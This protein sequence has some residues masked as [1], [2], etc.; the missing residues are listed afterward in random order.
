MMN[1]RLFTASLL[2][3]A[4]WVSAGSTVRADHLDQ[5]L[6]E[7][8]PKIVEALRAK[9][10]HNVGVIRFRV[11]V[12]NKSDS[13][14]TGMLNGNM[15]ARLENALVVHAGADEKTALGII[16]DASKIASKHK[17]GNW[18]TDKSEREKMFGFNYPLAWGSK[19][20]KP[21]ALLTGLVEVSPDYSKANVS[22]EA[23]TADNTKLTQLVPKF[24]VTGDAPLLHDL[25]KSY[26]VA[27]RSVRGQ[28]AANVRN[29]IFKEVKKRDDDMTPDTPTSDDGTMVGDILFKLLS[30]GQLVPIKAGSNNDKMMTVEC[31]DQ[32]K[33]VTFSITNKGKTRLGIDVRLND[34]S[35]VLRQ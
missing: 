23:F 30:A 22:I 5:K 15:A 2:A 25:G 21:D 8:T 11:K 32:G 6:M 4:A 13:F 34:V 9:G 28:P 12:G 16:H 1:V 24:S 33:P 31:P 26:A 14:S 10:Y 20:V 3:V 27:S 17:V 35:L 18:Y 29:V 7:E 19:Q